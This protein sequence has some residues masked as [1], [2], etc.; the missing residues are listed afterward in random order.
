[1]K[2][3]FIYLI[4]AV[5]FSSFA[6]A[7]NVY[8]E[9]QFE[10]TA[11]CDNTYWPEISYNAWTVTHTSSEQYNGTYS[12]YNSGTNTGSNAREHD[13]GFSGVTDGVNVSL[14]INFG[15]TGN[16]DFRLSSGGYLNQYSVGMRTTESTT[17]FFYDSGSGVVNTGITLNLGTWYNINYIRNG[18]N[19]ELYIDG[20][21]VTSSA[22]T[23]IDMS[24][25]LTY[26]SEQ[27]YF[28]N[29]IAY[30]GNLTP[31]PATPKDITEQT[32]LVE[33]LGEVKF[34]SSS[35]VTI[36][37]ADYTIDVNNTQV[38]G[39]YNFNVEGEKNNVVYCELQIDGIQVVNVTRSNIEKELGSVSMMSKHFTQTDGEHTQELLCRKVSGDKKIKITNVVG[40]GHFM[41]NGDGDEI[42]HDSTVF[43]STV[44]SGSIMTNVENFTFTISNSTVPTNTSKHLVLEW[45]ATYENND[46]VSDVLGTYI[47]IFDNTSTSAFNCSYY[48]RTVTD[49]STGSVG[50][51]CLLKNVTTNATYTMRFYGNGTNAQYN[52]NMIAKEFIL[53]DLEIA[54]GQGVLVG[55][56]FS[57]ATDTKLITIPG[58]NVNHALANVFEKQA[59]SIRCNQDT[60]VNMY[61]TLNDTINLRTI[62]MTRD[63]TAGD[64][65]V[66]IGHDIFENVTQDDYNLSV[67]ANAG[68]V[69]ATCEL[70]GGA[71]IGYVTDTIATRDQGL[72]ITANDAYLGTE[73]Q[74]FTA[75]NSITVSTTDGEIFLPT[76]EML[77]NFTV[78]SDLYYNQSF[79]DWNTSNALEVNLTPYPYI[80]LTLNDVINSG[81]I[82]DFTI[83]L[84]TGEEYST[85]TGYLLFRV[86]NGTYNITIDSE[87]FALTNAIIVANSTYTDY[88]VD[89][90]LTN[91]INISLYDQIN[92]SLIT[93]EVTI[94][95]QGDS[96]QE[97][98]TT[99]TGYF[100]KSNLTS[101]TY[102]L[103]FT[104]DGYT[105]ANYPITVTNRSYQSLNAYLLT[106]T[107]NTEVFS[108][109]DSSTS[110]AVETATVS[111]SRIIDNSWTVISVLQSDISGSVTFEYTANTN[112]KFSITK[113]GYDVKEFNLNPIIFNSYTV[114]I[115][116]TTSEGTT[117]FN[118]VSVTNDITT[119]YN[120]L[121]NNI[122]FLFASASGSLETYGYNVIFDTEE[123]AIG[124][125]N[126]YGGELST[127][128]N[129]SG[130]S[131]GDKI[132]ITYFYTLSDGSAFNNTLSYT[133]DTTNGAEYTSAWNKGQT[134]GLGLLERVLIVVLFTFLVGGVGFLFSGLVGSGLMIEAILGYF[135]FIEFLPK[136]TMVISMIVIFIVT[137]WGASQ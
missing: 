55:S 93:S 5:V 53:D 56:T 41:R 99:S 29:F 25:I 131:I 6:S 97:A 30:T 68:T 108:I 80:N 10:T 50:G 88:V 28:D 20:T 75:I 43:S 73:I 113:N 63:F 27:T 67:Y 37:S 4:L 45:A 130:A 77:I 90:Y 18:N 117:D 38:Y 135:T 64:I 58:G 86:F 2:K 16:T 101:G 21:Y 9:A 46:G 136:W 69:G 51:D 52:F 44:T 120:N 79:V 89:V 34:D 112:Y 22:R 123:I 96:Y 134:Y 11:E 132:Y 62:D 31:A 47:E 121:E 71:G 128:I 54:G 106:S 105:N 129:I 72:Y 81:S 26:A 103:L 116:Q 110:E 85:T 57:G 35:L 109:K 82:N 13:M 74:N 39:E 115:D 92:G 100:Y 15:A 65:G 49:V 125:V 32:A 122:T 119:F 8:Y 126:A 12:C 7:A 3:I 111:I 118:P 98:N 59:Y 91:S 42:N 84:P 83:T 1:M 70:M 61:I 133:I 137:S 124:D 78:S 94:T 76:G 23:D 48:P 127:S 33:Q 66:M 107:G 114:W 102:N 87:R 24:T 19:I 60:T 95:F 104:A 14:W 17:E 40:I 36:L